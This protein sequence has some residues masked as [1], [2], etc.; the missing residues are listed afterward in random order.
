MT[1]ETRVRLSTDP[2]ARTII[3]ERAIGGTPTWKWGKDESPT[4]QHLIGVLGEVAFCQIVGRP[5]PASVN[6]YTGDPDVPPRTEVRT[7]RPPRLKVRPSGS[8]RGADEPDRLVVAMSSRELFEA[9]DGI[10]IP[11]KEHAARLLDA[12]GD[13][14]FLF[15]LAGYIRAE[16]AQQHYPLEDPGN[17][18]P[19]HFVPFSKLVP[20]DPGFHDICAWA[21]YRGHWQ[22]IWC[23]AEYLE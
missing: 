7:S 2:R 19:A 18:K 13:R 22:C 4:R 10:R 11:P 17:R 15:A 23:G 9:L 3:E 21:R 14:P 1:V 20:L 16:Y 8:G 12:I 5:W 6:T